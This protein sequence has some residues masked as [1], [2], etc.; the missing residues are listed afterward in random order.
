M[1]FANCPA[2]VCF[3]V[4]VDLFAADVS[5]C[6]GHPG[7]QTEK[8]GQNSRAESG[9]G[10]HSSDTIDC[11]TCEVRRPHK[12]T[13]WPKLTKLTFHQIISLEIIT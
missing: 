10:R 1:G 12:P 13:S 11:R 6:P 4:K 2:C 9:S 3:E 5:Q 8:L 7:L